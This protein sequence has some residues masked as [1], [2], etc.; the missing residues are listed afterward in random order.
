MTDD[1]EKLWLRRP[2]GSC[3]KHSYEFLLIRSASLRDL[4]FDQSVRNAASI[5]GFNHEPAEIRLMV[6][7]RHSRLVLVRL[8]KRPHLP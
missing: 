2:F 6:P 4:L 8:D 3:C 5:P 1:F 7:L